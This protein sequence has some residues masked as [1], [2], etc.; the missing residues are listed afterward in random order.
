MTQCVFVGF[1]SL[2][3]L[4]YSS[5]RPVTF[6]CRNRSGTKEFFRV[7]FDIINAHPVDSSE[8]DA[9]KEAE[10]EDDVSDEVD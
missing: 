4:V 5:C 3:D 6:V 9:P 1:V 10:A 7:V 2:S 8:T